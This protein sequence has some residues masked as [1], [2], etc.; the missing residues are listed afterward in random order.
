MTGWRKLEDGMDDPRVGGDALTRRRQQAIH[1]VMQLMGCTHRRGDNCDHVD[2]IRL[3]GEHVGETIVFVLL[4]A[5]RSLPRPLTMRDIEAAA[6][7]IV[8]LS[9]VAANRAEERRGS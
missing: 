3:V 7:S 2:A 4:E 1:D 9:A 6:A 5:I 8:I